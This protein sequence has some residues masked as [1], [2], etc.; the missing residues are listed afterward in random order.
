MSS[1]SVVVASRSNIRLKLISEDCELLGLCRDILGRISEDTW[2]IAAA[3]PTENTEDALCLWDFQPNRTLPRA[4]VTSPLRHLFLV[5][6]TDLPGF[7]LQLPAPEAKVLLKPVTRATLEAFLT[8]TLATYD[9]GYTAESLR[10]DRDEILQ[11][12][13]QTNLRLQEYDQDRTT[14]LA[15]A[16]HDF[17]A[18]LTALTGYCGLLLA[19]PL[20]PLSANQK[21]ILQ[22]MHHSAKRLTRM[23][24][25]MFQ[26]SIGRHVK[27]QPELAPGDI[28]ECFEQALHDI[29]PFADDKSLTI[30][31]DFTPCDTPLLFEA[32]HIEQVLINILDNACKFTP[33]G[34]SIEVRGYPYFWERRV[35][36]SSIPIGADRRQVTS[37]QPNTYRVDIQDSGARI[38]PEYLEQI[39]EEYTSYA[40]GRDRSGGGLGLAITRMLVTQHEGRVWAENTEAGPMFSFVLPLQR[41]ESSLNQR[42]EKTA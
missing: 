6:R 27:T 16:V 14:F 23:A 9:S 19:E 33:K 4:V 3:G 22:R 26:L 42:H 32:G 41:G 34:G 24:N 13:I 28:R 35:S 11:C 8:E 29:T 18:P 40:G 7:R 17:R 10:A 5:S 38:P 21:E 12:L 36:R 31:A 37:R 1:L 2:E 20:G 15:R 30:R 25:A 39:F